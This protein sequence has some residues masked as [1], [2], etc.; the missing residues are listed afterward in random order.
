MRHLALMAVLGAMAARS[1][2][3]SLP[4]TRAYRSRPPPPPPPRGV[5]S[6][7]CP[8]CKA[9]VNEPCDRRTRGRHA[10]HMARV[11]AFREKR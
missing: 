1:G 3:D 11:E 8:R 6:V 5:F 4:A 2:D 10:H 7:V 9:G